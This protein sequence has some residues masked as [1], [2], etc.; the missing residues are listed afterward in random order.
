MSRTKRIVVTLAS[1]I[2]PLANLSTGS[3]TAGF[4]EF[5]MG[6]VEDTTQMNHRKFIGQ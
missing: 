3:S 1:I 4:S 2:G 5:S 6:V